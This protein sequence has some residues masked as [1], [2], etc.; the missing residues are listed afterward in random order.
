M[1]EVETAAA[2]QGS[3][4]VLLVEDSEDV[5]YLIGRILGRDPR[6]DVVA[7]ASDTA[8]ALAEAKRHQPD[9]ILLDV[10]LPARSGLDIMAELRAAV[11]RARIIVLTGDHRPEI[12]AAVVASGALA[13]VAKRDAS[14]RL[15]AIMERLLDPS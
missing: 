1:N 12:N 10:G 2:T 15:P 14:N 13:Y 5:R 6:I 3:L 7:E 8:G 9:V 4:S 11:P